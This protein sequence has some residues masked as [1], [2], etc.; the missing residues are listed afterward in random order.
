MK[1][2]IIKRIMRLESQVDQIKDAQTVS[3]AHFDQLDLSQIARMV[4]TLATSRKRSQ[5]EC[6]EIYRDFKVFRWIAIAALV[7][8]TISLCMAMLK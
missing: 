7:L 3:T 6:R 4:D 8:A 5:F 2:T 1:K